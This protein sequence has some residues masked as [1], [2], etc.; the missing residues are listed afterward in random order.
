MKA[1]TI[2]EIAWSVHNHWSGFYDLD[3]LMLNDC[4]SINDPMIEN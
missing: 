4:I 1:E 2:E 3:K